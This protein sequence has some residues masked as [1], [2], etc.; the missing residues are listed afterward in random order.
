MTSSTATT[1]SSAQYAIGVDVGG[2][3]TDLILS[4]PGG[5]RR[6][7][8]FTTHEDYAQGIFHS[9]DVVSGTLGISRQELLSRCGSIINGST[10]VTNA[11]TELRGARVGVLITRGFRDTFRLAGGPRSTDL[12]DH[13]QVPPPDIVDRRDIEEISERTV[14]EG[15]T[16]VDVDA[17]EVRAAVRRLVDRGVEAFAVCYLWSFAN[18]TNEQKTTEIIA[19]EAPELFI[20]QSSEVHPVLGEYP[21]FVTAVLNSLSHSA[22]TRYVDALADQLQ[23]EGFSGSLSF[24]QGIGG[25][26]QASAVH[27][28]PVSLMQSGPAGGVMGARHVA[29][30][31]GLDN[32]LVG[33]MG[34]TSFDA[35]VL[36]NLEPGITKQAKFGPLKTGINMLDIVS[37]GAGGGSTV[38]LDARGVPRVGPESAGSDPGPACYGR[39]GQAPTVTD[40][41]VVL[42]FID[43]D[44]YLQGR[45]DIDVGAAENAIR[46]GVAG[47]LGCEV[48]TGAAAI[49]DLATIEMANALRVV[50]IERGHHPRDF[51]FFSYGGGL[52]L[53]VVEICRRLGVP[54]IVV[55]DNSAA[56]SAYGVLIA[57]YLRQYDHTVNWNLKDVDRVSEVNA[58][59]AELEDRAVADA[60]AEGI[61]RSQL[62]FE[63]T[64]DFRFLGQTYEVTVPLPDSEFDEADAARMSSDFP[65]I[66]EATYGAGTAWKGTA[67]QLLNI[68]LRA[69]Y[70]RPKPKGRSATVNE[71]FTPEVVSKRRVFLPT[72]R[73][74]SDVPVYSETG[75][76]PGAVVDGPC[77]ID[78]GDTTIYG[79]AKSRIER[80]AY[81]N[82]MI[83]TNGE[84]EQQ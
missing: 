47:P 22:T 45:H 19:H 54:R 7:K 39:G 1:D 67:V 77:I 13:Q 5:L 4:T 56:F 50:S 2:T 26:V 76:Q 46:K 43:P 59:M 38:S 52:G 14:S 34:G 42:G 81:F 70:E 12:D 74:D 9:I 27:R 58:V 57:D 68:S 33:D 37:V 72:E 24:F 18:P 30:R 66:Y 84:D 16:V 60:Q 6:G 48:R 3:H 32:V 49:Y 51:T 69:V 61:D 80:D 40:A 36:P 83:T 82:F 63:K 44:N 55:P 20:T 64:G 71:G 78:V 29:Q 21:R 31:L 79:P 11:I 65:S 35:A 23:Q 73:V 75:L 8:A 62:K 41:N 53:F 10:I 28:K 25:S 15:D 17:D